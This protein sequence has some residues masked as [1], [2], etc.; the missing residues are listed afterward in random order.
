M[1]SDCCY[2]V[3]KAAAAGAAPALKNFCSILHCPAVFTQNLGQTLLD[4]K[5][6]REYVLSVLIVP[7]HHNRTHKIMHHAFKTW[8]IVSMSGRY[9]IKTTVFDT[10]TVVFITFRAI[11]KRSKIQSVFISVFI[12]K[13]R[14]L[15]NRENR[16]FQT[17]LWLEIP[18]I[19]SFRT[20]AR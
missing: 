5:H 1:P 2:F 18:I 7:A 14:F 15:K 16:T 4:G 11:F 12:A 13:S 10:K 9:A 3:D 19:S 8:C 17:T 20:F 6:Y